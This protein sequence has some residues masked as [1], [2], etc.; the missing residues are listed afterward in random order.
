MEANEIE[1]YAKS[2][3]GRTIKKHVNKNFIGKSIVA[4]IFHHDSMR[5]VDSAKSLS[6]NAG[7]FWFL[8]E[9]ESGMLGRYESDDYPKSRWT[10]YPSQKTSNGVSYSDAKL[11]EVCLRS[12]ELGSLTSTVVT[13][14]N[15]PWSNT[16]DGETCGPSGLRWL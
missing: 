3:I 14:S 6:D 2:F 13:R 16:P 4:L 8:V 1:N 7:N 9:C 15:D 11:R 5:R 12:A 10:K